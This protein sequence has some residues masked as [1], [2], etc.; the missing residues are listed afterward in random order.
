MKYNEE[1]RKK[2]IKYYKDN[3]NVK[4]KKDDTNLG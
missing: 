2:N 4:K 3:S 1:R